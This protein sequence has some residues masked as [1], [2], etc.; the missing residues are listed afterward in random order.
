MVASD[1]AVV[2][3][4]STTVTYTPKGGQGSSISILYDY[5]SDLENRGNYA[6]PVLAALVKKSDVSR[7]AYGDTITFSDSTIWT[8]QE[9]TVGD[10]YVWRVLAHRDIRA[11]L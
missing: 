11:V 9:A 1:L 6:G 10:G 5:L 4:N 3:E 2:F 8:I 7:P